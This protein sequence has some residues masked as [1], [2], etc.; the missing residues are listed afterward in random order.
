MTRSSGMLICGFFISILAGTTGPTKLDGALYVAA[1]GS[2]SNPGTIQLPLRTIQHA[3]EIAQPGITVYIRGGVYCQ[4]LLLR[5]SGNAHD[6]FITFRSSPGEKAVLDGEC[7]TQAEGDTSMVELLD[8]SYVR[9]QDLEIRNLRTSVPRTVPWGIRVSGSGSHIEILENDVHHIEQNAS[10]GRRSG[11]AG[12]G[13]GIGV[14]GTNGQMPI[15]D[16]VIDGN[17]VHHLKTGLSESVVVNGNVAGFR[18]SRNKVHDN[19]NIGIDMIG[20]EQVAPDPAV[21]RARD[22]VVRENLVY[23]ITSGSRPGILADADGIYVDGGTR[24]LIE[25][26]VVHD[27]DF[28]ISLES[29]HFGR[30]TSQVVARNNLIYFCHAAGLDIGGYDAKRGGTED[31][32]IVNNTLYRNDVWHVGK[33]EFLMMFY[34]RKNVFKNNIIFTHKRGQVFQSLSPRGGNEPTVTMDHNLYYIPGDSKNA[35]WNYDKVE[36]ANF[37]DYVGS[38]G[39]D[40]NSRLR[41]P[42]FIDPERNDFHLQPDSPGRN[43][44]IVIVSGTN[45]AQDLD[46]RPRVKGNSI[47]AG[48]YQG[49]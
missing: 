20:F 7:L 45:G 18:I 37:V 12:N 36:Y 19:N 43:A 44:G 4:R 42:R 2:D 11:D 15:S 21:D 13:I 16:L 29:E 23:N 47:D 46:G 14:Y 39:Y 30:S 9:V 1:N 10:T 25:R 33:G 17:E 3:A 31:V 28:G 35:K 40:I 8:A 32:V 26:N 27:V 22:G 38:T 5:A 34:M 48:C 24:I 41:D 6:G 49:H